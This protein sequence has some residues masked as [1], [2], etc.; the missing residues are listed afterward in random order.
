MQT[1]IFLLCMTGSSLL[2]CSE[3]RLVKAQKKDFI[4]QDCIKDLVAKST[5]LQNMQDGSI[6]VKQKDI[7]QWELSLEVLASPQQLF[8]LEKSGIT[9]CSE[10]EKK[11]CMAKLTM[12]ESAQGIELMHKLDIHPYQIAF[13]EQLHKWLDKYELLFVVLHEAARCVKDHQTLSSLMTAKILD[14]TDFSGLFATKKNKIISNNAYDKNVSPDGKYEIVFKDKKTHTLHLAIDCQTEH[15]RACLY[16]KRLP[17][18]HKTAFCWDRNQRYIWLAISVCP[19]DTTDQLPYKVLRFDLD[20]MRISNVLSLSDPICAIT[21]SLDGNYVLFLV[22]EKKVLYIYD[23]RHDFFITHKVRK[24]AQDI[25]FS[26][27]GTY[28]FINSNN[29]GIQINFSKITDLMQNILKLPLDQSALCHL[30]L[31]TKNK[32]IKKVPEVKSIWSLVPQAVRH[33]INKGLL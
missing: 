12:D 26:Q 33:R 23:T 21:C 1:L 32:K 31:S 3:T 20:A 4:L 28:V 27:D 5:V 9:S 25:V 29:H 14:K 13:Q 2:V 16:H 8:V 30:L 22:P 24:K 11:L 7:K 18:C 19:S 6:H 15:G 10:E 17:N